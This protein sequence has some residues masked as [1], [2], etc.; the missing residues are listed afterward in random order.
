M[1]LEIIGLLLAFFEKR[2]GNSKIEKP[3]IHAPQN[4]QRV[5]WKSILP[6]NA[7]I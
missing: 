4:V 2:I 6:L 5:I 1:P 7:T 3:A